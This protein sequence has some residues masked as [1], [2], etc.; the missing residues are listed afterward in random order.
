MLRTETAVWLL[1]HGAKWKC[2]RGLLKSEGTIFTRKSKILPKKLNEKPI[3]GPLNLKQQRAALKQG[4]HG[5]IVASA[6]HLTR[7]E[8]HP[9][10]RAMEN[11]RQE[12][13]SKNTNKTELGSTCKHRT[14]SKW[15]YLI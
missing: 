12:N 1:V 8:N 9:E 11:N 15:S 14:S 13:F 3:L 4:K 6:S 10:G 2:P 7:K 5:T